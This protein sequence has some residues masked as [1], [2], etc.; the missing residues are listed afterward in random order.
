MAIIIGIIILVVIVIII[1]NAFSSGNGVNSSCSG[2]GIS[3]TQKNLDWQTI[4]R[5]T[6]YNLTKSSYGYTIF[7]GKCGTYNNAGNTIIDGDY[8]LRSYYNNDEYYF[9]TKNFGK[10]CWIRLDLD[11]IN[12]LRNVFVKYMEWEEKAS[13]E[14][15]KIQKEIPGSTIISHIAWIPLLGEDLCLGEGLVITCIFFSQTETR[16]QLVITT[17]EIEAIN[18]DRDEF[19]F[20]DKFKLDGRYFDKDRVVEFQNAISEQNLTSE[21]KK[22]REEFEKLE[23]AT[24]AKESF[25]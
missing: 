20:R 7:K 18:S 2:E 9:Y 5:N 4:L 17:N 13:T 25:A 15:V 21:G 1:K 11:A 14:K 23:R 10:D 22:I 12:I 3:P 24:V 8:K 19:K 16:H 6:K